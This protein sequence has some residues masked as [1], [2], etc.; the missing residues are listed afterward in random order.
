MVYFLYT[1]IVEDICPQFYLLKKRMSIKTKLVF[2]TTLILFLSGLLMWWII[3]V[4][5]NKVLTDHINADVTTSIDYTFQLINFHLDQVKNNLDVLAGDP[6][7][8]SALETGD[9]SLLD[10]VSQKMEIINQADD[11]IEHIGLQSIAGTACILRTGDKGTLPFVGT[12]FSGRDYCQEI[13]RTK[14]DYLSSA[15]VSSVD[16]DMVLSLAVPVKNAG[17]EVIGDIVS[18]ISL[19]ELRGY[20][21]NLRKDSSTDLL[22]RSGALFLSTETM[23]ERLDE[24][25]NPQEKEINEVKK[26]LANN[27][28]E[29]YFRDADTFYGYKSTGIITVIF[30]KSSTSLLDLTRILD[31][32]VF[33]SLSA[34]IVLTVLVT[35]LVVQSITR[36]I[37]RL[38]GIAQ[39]ITDGQF[40]ID[41][42]RK[43]FSGKDETAVLAMALFT[44]VDKLKDLYESLEQKV[45][46]RTE[47][48]EQSEEK[49]RELLDE[50]ERTN[51]LMVGRELEMIKLKEQLN[52][53]R[54]KRV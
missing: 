12:D 51:R 16:K 22:D 46:E 24:A 15:F 26:R 45:K 52:E 42:E 3:S 1:F 19:S 54:N 4:Q 48:L 8:I 11:S 17:G 13:I 31:W 10:Q 23:I 53:I 7:T 49:M 38:S 37:S 32:T 30:E 43:D 18:S 47:K 39:K 27:E 21:L 44:M 9:Q 33:L 36:R 34:A 5:N 25:D 20:L 40:D 50:S 14:E 29:G 35:I 6:L 41:L 2:S 28:R